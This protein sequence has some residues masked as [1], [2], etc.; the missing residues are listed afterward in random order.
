MIGIRPTLPRQLCIARWATLSSVPF[1]C[2]WVKSS[3]M[4]VTVTKSATGKPLTT[5]ASVMPAK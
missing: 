4:P 3:V 5:V 1:S 2:A